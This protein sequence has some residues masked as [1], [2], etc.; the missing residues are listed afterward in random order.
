MK[1]V[2]V[3]CF[4]ITA[5]QREDCGFQAWLTLFNFSKMTIIT[6]EVYKNNLYKPCGRH[7]SN[8]GRNMAENKIKSAFNWL[9][10][11]VGSRKIMP[12]SNFFSILSPLYIHISKKF[13][14]TR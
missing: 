12:C 11:I 14:E 2:M 1:T 5:F 13:A 7:V 6:F 3:Y 8:I 10:K 4:Y 9:A